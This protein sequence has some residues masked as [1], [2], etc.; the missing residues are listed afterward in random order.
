VVLARPSAVAGHWPGA[1]ERRRREALLRA[2]YTPLIQHSR[3]VGVGVLKARHQVRVLG[4]GKRIAAGARKRPLAGFALRRVI[5]SAA[6]AAMNSARAHAQRN[7]ALGDHTWRLATH[8]RKHGG[9]ILGRAALAKRRAHPRHRGASNLKTQG[10][11]NGRCLIV[12]IN[13]DAARNFV[14]CSDRPRDQENMLERELPA[15]WSLLGHADG[16]NATLAHAAE[17]CVANAQVCL[18]RAGAL[19]PGVR[20][21]VANERKVLQC[22][23]RALCDTHA[24]ARRNHAKFSRLSLRARIHRSATRVGGLGAL[25]FGRARLVLLQSGRS[26]RKFTTYTLD[27]VS[28]SSWCSALTQPR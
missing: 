13:F 8:G 9:S 23:S 25:V 16:L 14:C 22:M 21:R 19:P 3:R 2:E 17:S 20:A 12:Q 18:P 5:S 6:H 11:L 26:S 15:L 7:R 27:R 4:V 28:R 24:C 1:D 10:P